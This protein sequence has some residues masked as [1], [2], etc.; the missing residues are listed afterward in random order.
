MAA[1][2]T[3]A[4]RLALALATIHAAGPKTIRELHLN[5]VDI[6]NRR[7]AITGRARPLDDLSGRLRLVFLP[8]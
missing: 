1:A 3:P 7:L 8:W 5:D 2:V 4:A 6:C